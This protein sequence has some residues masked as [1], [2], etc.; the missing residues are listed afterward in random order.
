MCMYA[1]VDTAYGTSHDLHPF[2]ARQPMI[3]SARRSE[4]YN[5]SRVDPRLPGMGN[6]AV[7]SAEAPPPGAVLR[8]FA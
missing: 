5:P 3:F 4:S 7:P 6:G 1:F 2:V 8:I